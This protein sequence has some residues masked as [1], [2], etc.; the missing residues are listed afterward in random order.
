MKGHIA[1]FS[2]AHSD[3]K[4]S[5]TPVLIFQRYGN[6]YFLHEI[7]A[8]NAPNVAVPPLKAGVEKAAGGHAAGEQSDSHRAQVILNRFSL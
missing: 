7:L 5:T 2:A 4:R 3:D 1:E 8:A 6:Q